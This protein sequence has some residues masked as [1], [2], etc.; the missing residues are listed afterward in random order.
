[1]HRICLD[2]DNLGTILKQ[3]RVRRG[4]PYDDHG[5]LSQEATKE[6]LLRKGRPIKNL[7]QWRERLRKREERRRKHRRKVRGL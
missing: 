7:D 2:L 3:C 6:Y 5:K 1:M 4:V